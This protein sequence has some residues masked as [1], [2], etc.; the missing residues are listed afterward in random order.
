MAW[1]VG[2]HCPG[3]L[4][5]TM[6]AG[7]TADGKNT[8]FFNPRVVREEKQP[9][10]KLPMLY[11]RQHSLF[12]KKQNCTL[13]ADIM[14]WISFSQHVRL[15]SGMLHL[16][17]STEHNEQGEVRRRSGAQGCHSRQR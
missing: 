11:N 16:T 7:E 17:R 2:W 6:L 14:D 4:V 8:G 15:A 5:P 12:L 9:S 3:V 1:Y 13:T 10:T